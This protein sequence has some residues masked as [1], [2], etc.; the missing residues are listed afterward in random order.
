MC[1]NLDHLVP[2]VPVVVVPVV[3]VNWRQIAIDWCHWNAGHQGLDRTLSLMKESFWWPGMAN[4][5]F[6]VIQ[7]CGRVQRANIPE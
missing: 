3:P 1:D 2:V 5:L 7:N 6:L 4:A